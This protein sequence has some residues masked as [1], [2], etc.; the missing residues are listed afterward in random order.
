VSEGVGNEDGEMA[1]NGNSGSGSSPR[2]VFGNLL[3]HYRARAGLSQDQLGARVYLSGDMIGKIEQGQRTPNDQFVE[4]CEALT[5]LGTNGA[6][7]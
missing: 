1:S 7:A 5:E 3:R 4:A 2:R 6:F